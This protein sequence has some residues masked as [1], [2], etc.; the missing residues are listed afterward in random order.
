MSVM[1]MFRHLCPGVLQTQGNILA[2]LVLLQF[3]CNSTAKLSLWGFRGI[4]LHGGGER[5]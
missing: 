1:A 4:E 2:K 3:N 5:S